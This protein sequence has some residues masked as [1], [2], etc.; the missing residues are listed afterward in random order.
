MENQRSQKETDQEKLDQIRKAKRRKE[1]FFLV[2][3]TL[4]AVALIYWTHR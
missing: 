3:F 2:V 4:S 1:I